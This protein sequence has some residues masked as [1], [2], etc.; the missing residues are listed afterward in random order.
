MVST[1]IVGSL[2]NTTLRPAAGNGWLNV[3]RISD[4]A[5]PDYIHFGEEHIQFAPL[6]SLPIKHNRM[7]LGPKI[8]CRRS[9]KTVSHVP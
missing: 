1:E 4:L 9:E 3:A 5:G 7:A 2:S 8:A 6:R